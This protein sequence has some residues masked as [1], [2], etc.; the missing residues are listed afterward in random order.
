ML[1]ELMCLVGYFVCRYNS[2]QYMAVAIL[3]SLSGCARNHP[4]G[5]K[6]D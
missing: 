1:Y 6:D 2:L 4:C 5:V 3:L